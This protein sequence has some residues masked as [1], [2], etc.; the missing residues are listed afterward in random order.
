MTC[1]VVNWSNKIKTVPSVL[2]TTNMHSECPK[3]TRLIKGIEASTKPFHPL[4]CNNEIPLKGCLWYQLHTR[5]VG[6]FQGKVSSLR[7]FWSLFFWLC[8]DTIFLKQSGSISLNISLTL[9]INLRF[10]NFLKNLYLKTL[11]YLTNNLLTREE[12]SGIKVLFKGQYLHRFSKT[13]LVNRQVLLVPILRN[14]IG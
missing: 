4:P 1:K 7:L 2:I 10:Q 13:I 9:V 14:K 8:T 11:D 5:G 3:M 6:Y 12:V